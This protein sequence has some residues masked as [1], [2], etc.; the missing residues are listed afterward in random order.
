[1]GKLIKVP[2]MCILS[3]GNRDWRDIVMHHTMSSFYLSSYPNYVSGNFS[4][5]DSKMLKENKEV[6][7]CQICN[8]AIDHLSTRKR[9][10]HVN[11]YVKMLL[12]VH[13]VS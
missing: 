9:T 5:K 3:V 4:G 13:S 12:F 6:T 7:R 11:R 8:R 10:E 2:G 1:M